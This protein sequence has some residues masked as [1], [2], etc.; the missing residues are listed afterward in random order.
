MKNPRES[1]SLTWQI[2]WSTAKNALKESI[3]DFLFHGNA[4][5]IAENRTSD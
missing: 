4:G 1:Y 2:D 5:E 3:A